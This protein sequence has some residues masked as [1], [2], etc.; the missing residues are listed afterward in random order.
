MTRIR[1]CAYLALVAAALAGCGMATDKIDSLTG[2]QL[3]ERCADYVAL[4]RAYDAVSLTRAIDPTETA[5]VIGVKVF[6][7]AKCPAALV[8]ADVKAKL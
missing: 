5:I 6:L 8:P 1:T 3:E 7:A 4:F 2:T